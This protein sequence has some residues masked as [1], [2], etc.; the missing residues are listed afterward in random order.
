MDGKIVTQP[1]RLRRKEA[2]RYLLDVWS[3]SRTPSTLAKLACV[4]GG[5]KFESAGR[6]PLYQPS[7]LDAWV[8]SI[9]TG[10]RASTSDAGDI[11][12]AQAKEPRSTTSDASEGQ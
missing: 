9:M 11:V 5:P 1:R 3:I 2:S 4:G 6:I 7:Q 8:R 12:D 10:L